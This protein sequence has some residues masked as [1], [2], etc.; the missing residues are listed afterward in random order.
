MEKE[1]GRKKELHDHGLFCDLVGLESKGG[2]TGIR[3]GCSV[4]PHCLYGQIAGLFLNSCVWE[5]GMGG[6][7]G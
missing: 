5:V 3:I 6:G 2:E 7:R 4:C 1:K